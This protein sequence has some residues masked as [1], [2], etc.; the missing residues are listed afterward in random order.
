V[1]HLRKVAAATILGTFIGPGC[2]WDYP[3]WK[4]GEG[5]RILQERTL[6]LA[7]RPSRHT[8]SGTTARRG[9]KA[10]S[11]LRHRA[12][13]TTWLAQRLREIVASSVAGK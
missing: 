4:R 8:R 2:S 1:Q 10:R 7:G 6:H 13:F 5:V 3:V 11:R 12:S 9:R